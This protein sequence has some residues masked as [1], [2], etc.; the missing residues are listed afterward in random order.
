MSDH[1]IIRSVA[2]LEAEDTDTLLYIDSEYESFQYADVTG[3]LELPA[4][5]IRDG[6]EVRTALKAL[7]ES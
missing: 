5:V 6:A 1:R 7:E 4:V 2:E 3:G